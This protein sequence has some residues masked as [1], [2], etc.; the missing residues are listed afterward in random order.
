MGSALPLTNVMA[1]G[2]LTAA[3][4]VRL[5]PLSRVVEAGIVGDTNEITLI[6]Y[7]A[8]ATAP[9]E[10]IAGILPLPFLA[11]LLIV[12]VPI[13]PEIMKTPPLKVPNCASK[14]ILPPLKLLKVKGTVTVLFAQKGLPDIVP[15]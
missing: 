6:R 2:L 5:T 1:V 3:L 10:I 15:V 13:V 7:V 14:L 11:V 4:I 9:E 8:P 12:T